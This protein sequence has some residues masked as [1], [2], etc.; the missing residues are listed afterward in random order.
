MHDK[1]YREW[2][3][4]SPS[5]DSAFC[6]TCWLPADKDTPHYDPSFSNPSQGFSRWKKATE[7]LEKHEKSHVHVKAVTDMIKCRFR[8]ET[9]STVCQEQQVSA[10]ERQVRHNRDVLR[11]LLDIILFLGKQ[12]LRFRGHRETRFTCL[13]K[14]SDSGSVVNDGNFLEM[15]K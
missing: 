12:N 7:C 13:G 8:I 15:V 4:Y 5:K 6:F 3:A 10:Y 2:L 1:V 11:R 14:D 9:G